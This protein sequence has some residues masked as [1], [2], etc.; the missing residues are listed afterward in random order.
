MSLRWDSYDKKKTVTDSDGDSD[1]KKKKVSLCDL[2]IGFQKTQL[3]KLQYLQNKCSVILSWL[4]V[5]E[6]KSQWFK[7]YCKLEFPGQH[8]TSF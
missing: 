1:K 7:L 6:K 2:K 4:I 8:K 5:K 3:K